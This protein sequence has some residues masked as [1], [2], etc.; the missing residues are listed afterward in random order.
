[1]KANR[2]RAR[3]HMR[4][5][6]QSLMCKTNDKLYFY[7]QE[8]WFTRSTDTNPQHLYFTTDEE[9]KEGDWCINSKK[10]LF[11]VKNSTGNTLHNPDT[12]EPYQKWGG[13]KVIASTDSKL[14]T[15]ECGNTTHKMSCK[16]RDIKLPQPSQAFIKAYSEQGGID[17]VDVEME[18]D[19]YG[20]L[21]TL[22]DGS[23]EIVIAKKLKAD[24]VHNTIT[25]HRIMSKEE[26]A[27]K[28]LEMI[29]SEWG[30]NWDLLVQFFGQETADK[31]DK[32]CG[33]KS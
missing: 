2:E 21:F 19:N 4:P 24:P 16:N 18:D 6:E 14:T 11:Q 9:I 17:E 15:C 25:T 7:P 22:K 29:H 27:L 8:N 5:T 23:T 33:Y 10:E 26:E 12:K 32:I 30:E 3:I 31:W 20:A 1:M 28:F 13:R